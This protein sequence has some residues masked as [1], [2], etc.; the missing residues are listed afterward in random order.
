ML[1]KSRIPGEQISVVSDY[2]EL[3]RVREFVS[4]RALSFGFSPED[5]NKIALAVDEA[6]S[7]IIRH[8]YNKDKR[9]RITVS[10]EV[11]GKQFSIRIYDNGEPFDP[12][13]VPKQNMKK[14]MKTYQKGGLGLHLMR[15]VMDD[16]SYFPADKYNGHNLL[17][18]HKYLK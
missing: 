6:C 15:L 2:A 5:T 9:R 11:Q 1:N 10:V 3:N 7:N 8:A 17:L 16:I 4:S 14:Y 12:Q 13:M 18:L